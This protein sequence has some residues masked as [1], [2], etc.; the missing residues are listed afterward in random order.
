MVDN[1]MHIPL[2]QLPENQSLTTAGR[3]RKTEHGWAIFNAFSEFAL[4]GL[5]DEGALSD[6]ALIRVGGYRQRETLQVTALQVVHRPKNGPTA[7]GRRQSPS[8]GEALRARHEI[9]RRIRHFFENRDFLEVETPASLRAPGTDPHLDPVPIELGGTGEETPHLPAYLHTSPELMMKQLLAAGAGPIYQLCRVWR[10]AEVT[11]LHTPEFTLLEWYRPWRSVEVIID[12]VEKLVAQIL[13][14]HCARPIAT[15]IARMTMQQVVDAACGFDLLEALDAPSLR[16]EVLS[17]N[18]LSERAVGDAEW[19]EIFF[20]LSISHIDPYLKTLGA[21]FVT[22]WPLP[23]AVLARGTDGEP[24]TAE[25]FE[26]YVD[27]LELANGFGELTDPDEQRRRFRADNE[28]RSEL[29]LPRLP[30]PEAFLRA[31]NWGMPPSAGVALGVDRLLLLATDGAS[32]LRDVAPFALT[33][34]D[35]GIHWPQ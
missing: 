29:N 12:D 23:L 24:R 13:D 2:H 35:R 28:R 10:G 15:P 16:R 8:L 20:S 3:L 7:L 1:S 27:G 17:R 34:D 26:L 11:D 30:I 33:R 18:L 6:G 19:D 22:D 14:D 32:T 25:R 4:R 21:V 31:L 5:D 9:N